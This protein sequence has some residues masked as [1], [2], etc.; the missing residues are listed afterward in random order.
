MSYIDIS[1]IKEHDICLFQYAVDGHLHQFEPPGHE[2]SR[3][4]HLSFNDQGNK[5]FIFFSFLV[6]DYGC[7]WLFKCLFI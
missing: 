1:A 4:V 3:L 5:V 2:N 6:W 7:R